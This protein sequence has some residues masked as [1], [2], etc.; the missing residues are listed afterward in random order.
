M[1][2]ENTTEHKNKGSQVGASFLDRLAE[3]GF[4]IL[5]MAAMFG[6]AIAALNII[7]E[8]DKNNSANI[9]EN[10][11]V[12]SVFFGVLGLG[13]VSVEKLQDRDRESSIKIFISLA[14]ILFS[15]TLYFA[16]IIS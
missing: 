5:S 3:N 2:T 12:F 4:V 7:Q 1:E 16:F 14:M 10:I 6:F 11:A 8:V 15:I 13:L 9:A